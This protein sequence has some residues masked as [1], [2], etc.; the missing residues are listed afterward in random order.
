[1]RIRRKLGRLEAVIAVTVLAA[2]TLVGAAVSAQPAAADAVCDPS[3]DVA[4]LHTWAVDF[5]SRGVTLCQGTDGTN[6][7]EAFV[8]II[9]LSAGAKIRMIWDSCQPSAQCNQNEFLN[10]KSNVR[11][12]SEWFDW[13]PNH[14]VVPD[15]SRLFSTSNASFFTDTSGAPSPLSLPFMDRRPSSLGGWYDNETYGAAYFHNDDPAWDAP[16][17]YI[18]FDNPADT[19]QKVYFGDFPT[20]YT[21]NDL[22]GSGIFWLPGWPV[23]YDVTVGFT[24]DY[25]GGT[26][27][28]PRTFVGESAD[29][30]GNITKLYILNTSINKPLTVTDAQAL[31]ESFGSEAEIQLDGGGSAQLDAHTDLGEV[32]FASDAS[33]KVPNA[34]AV[35]L[36]P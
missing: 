3:F 26:G 16:K 29:A 19:P 6:F 17:R 20:H 8:Q 15:G 24:P 31:L 33:R 36:A 4:G 2:G 21:E 7:N 12:A 30:S 25:D 28:A 27:Q 32:G 9:D 10:A 13:I 23:D 14:V 34:L 5:N 11:S 35:Y 22:Q 1:M 18:G